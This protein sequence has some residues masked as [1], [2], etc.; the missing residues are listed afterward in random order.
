MHQLEE[1]DRKI[2]KD[3]RYKEFKQEIHS[4]L[5]SFDK[6]NRSKDWADL[7]RSLQK[8]N[9]S[10]RKYGSKVPLLPEKLGIMKRISQCLNPSLSPGVHMKTLETY[11]EI[12][13]HITVWEEDRQTSTHTHIHTLVFIPIMAIYIYVVCDLM[14][15]AVCC[16]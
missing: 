6:S 16:C 11:E 1:E 13:K 5:Q 3:Y 14:I 9:K 8:L 12:L 10:I 15:G 7:I 4:V 2:M